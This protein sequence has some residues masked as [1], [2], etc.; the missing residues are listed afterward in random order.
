M[1]SKYYGATIAHLLY[2]IKS[3]TVTE[4]VAGAAD[5]VR[6]H[7]GRVEFAQ[8]NLSAKAQNAAAIEYNKAV[9]TLLQAVEHEADT[10]VTN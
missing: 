9:E 8:G 1:A 6:L 5:S 7:D 2:L 4:A 3:A 10:M